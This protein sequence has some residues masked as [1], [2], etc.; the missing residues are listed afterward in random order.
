MIITEEKYIE[1]NL[2]ALSK[3]LYFVWRM[4]QLKQLPENFYAYRKW[5][6]SFQWMDYYTLEE[7]KQLKE[8]IFQVEFN[9]SLSNVRIF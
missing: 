4:L 7:I 9:H 6:P 5:K 3:D 1:D 2:H 8:I